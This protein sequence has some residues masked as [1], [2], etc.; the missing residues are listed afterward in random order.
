M[1]QNNKKA[2]ALLMNDVHVSKDNIPE[3]FK[4]WSEAIEVC[5]KY[6]ANVII[7]GGDLWQSRAS[8]SLD[9]LM[10][11]SNAL[12]Q[13]NSSR[14]SVYIANGNHDKVDGESWVGYND[15]YSAYPNVHII[16]TFETLKIAQNV[17]ISVMSYF[18]ETGSFME[19]YNDLLDDDTNI[20]DYNILY[21][22]EGIR[23]ALGM[24]LETELPNDIFGDFDAV[25]VG[26]Y[27]NRCK[28]KG[29]NIEYIGSSRQHNFGEDE[30]KGY[31]IVF[32]DGTTEFVKNQVNMR[33]VTIESKFTNAT[34]DTVIDKMEKYASNDLYKVR[35]Q[36][37]CDSTQSSLIDR[38]KLIEA[39][40]SKVEIKTDKVEV[41]ESVSSALEHK[42]DKFGI[43]GE[44]S[45][46]YDSKNISVNKEFGNKFLNQIK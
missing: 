43:I 5:K 46:F 37:S 6:G 14:I 35:L 13:C 36:I 26:H 3:F 7:I 25:L 28:I 20:S 9:V 40:A 33:Y 44:Y 4:N 11:I 38:Q 27:H 45:N 2:C 29:T 23:G 34:M 32:D 22:H 31:T 16:N 10:A 21:L 1:Q 30:E 18:P 17:S 41:E 12:L 8:Q 19:H 39:G 42:F 24:E 15:I